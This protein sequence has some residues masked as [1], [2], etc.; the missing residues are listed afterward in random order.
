MAIAQKTVSD[1]DPDFVGPEF[2]EE[3]FELGF[4]FGISGLPPEI[5]RA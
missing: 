5:F 1:N 2:V 4:V 3:W